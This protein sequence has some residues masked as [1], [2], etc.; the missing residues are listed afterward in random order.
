[1][2]ELV[3]LNDKLVGL[4]AGAIVFLVCIAFGYAVK[5][6][7][8]ISNDWMPTVVIMV[9]TAL[10]MALAPT[11]NFDVSLR[12]W[13]TRNFCVGFIIGFVAYMAH[14][15]ILKKLEDKFGGMEDPKDK[16]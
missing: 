9:G 12:I 10:F 7:K 1:M 14:K 8:R 6:S 4:P 5:M 16:S 3:D 11:R 13:L 2:E 15:F